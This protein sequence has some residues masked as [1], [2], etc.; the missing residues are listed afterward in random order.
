MTTH[1]IYQLQALDYV[2]KRILGNSNNI[3]LYGRDIKLVVSLDGDYWYGDFVQMQNR[4]STAAIQRKYGNDGYSDDYS[5]NNSDIESFKLAWEAYVSTI[6]TGSFS[7]NPYYTM[8]DLPNLYSY[9][10]K[11]AEYLNVGSEF[12]SPLH[13]YL[14]NAKTVKGDLK[15]PFIDLRNK[16]IELVSLVELEKTQ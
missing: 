1:N 16:E 14:L 3:N 8:Q 11:V 5:Y 7:S 12:E 9:I 4:N 2:L 10:S 13:P 15:L 6:P